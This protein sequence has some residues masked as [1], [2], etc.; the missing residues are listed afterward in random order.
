VAS[1]KSAIRNARLPLPTFARGAFPPLLRGEQE[2]LQ[3]LRDAFMI[4][5]MQVLSTYRFTVDEYHRLGEAGI[6]GE[7]DRVELLD[8]DLINMAPIGGEHRT[9]VDSLNLLLASRAQE[10]QYRIGIQN[11]ISLDPHS[12]PQPDVVLYDSSV[13]GRHPRP[14]EIYLLIEVA[15]SSLSYDVGP[16][17]A[18]YARVGIREVWVVDAIRR[19]VLVYRRPVQ[20]QYGTK[21]ELTPEDVVTIEAFPDVSLPVSRFLR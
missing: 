12:E 9:L 16:K 18:A 4:R 3:P 10:N 21:L 7:D 2:S 15:D 17:L 6:L 5:S 1:S 13:L 8:G 14:E 11:P 20:G 19:R